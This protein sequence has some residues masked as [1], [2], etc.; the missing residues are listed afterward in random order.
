MIV[1][2]D[3]EAAVANGFIPYLTGEIFVDDESFTLDR[4]RFMLSSNDLSI[5]MQANG[6]PIGQVLTKSINISL[7]NSD[8]FFDGENLK[9][10]RLYLNYG[11][12]PID[13]IDFGDFFIRQPNSY[14]DIIQFTAYDP[15][16]GVDVVF[17]NGDGSE[18]PAG[19]TANID[20][21]FTKTLSACGL[22]FDGTHMPSYYALY[23]TVKIPEGQIT[24]RK[25][26]EYILQAI[27]L[28]LVYSG[29]R[30]N[31]IFSGYKDPMHTDAYESMHQHTLEYD[32]LA[33][34]VSGAKNVFT[35]R[36]AVGNRVVTQILEVDSPYA[37][38]DIILQY[39]S[40]F[41]N[42]TDRLNTAVTLIAPLTVRKFRA[43]IPFN[44]LIEAMDKVHVTDWQGNDFYSYI[45]GVTHNFHGKTVIQ[46][47]L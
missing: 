47:T 14:G 32:R 11:Y 28:N 31:V 34:I 45:T 13:Y 30:N 33:H 16:Q 41:I 39:N 43:E 10:I 38:K 12:D 25:I 40:N 27:S 23:T 22:M 18:F 1:K 19:S 15:T 29:E 6:F 26:L 8:G 46:C 35:Y 24:C 9:T 4:N 37:E 42:S 21:L 17:D 20:T 36:D 7:D 44:P 2:P 5:G 3:Y